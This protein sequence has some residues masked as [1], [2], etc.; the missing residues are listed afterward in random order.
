MAERTLSAI[1]GSRPSPKYSSG[2]P[3]RRPFTSREQA[4][5]YSPDGHARRSSS[6]ADHGRR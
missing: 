3:M 2:M 1:A 6:R 5:S 4:A